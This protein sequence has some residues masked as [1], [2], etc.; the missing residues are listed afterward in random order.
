MSVSA[1]HLW[2]VVDG[3][4]LPHRREWDASSEPRRMCE[5]FEHNLRMLG[6][7]TDES[8]MRL[9]AEYRRF[10]Y[11]KALDGGG[12]TP[13]HDIDEAWHLHMDLGSDL[14]NAFAQATGRRIRHAAGL[15]KAERHAA[16]ARCW[17]LYQREFDCLP[18]QDIW[19]DPAEVR[20]RE[21]ARPWFWGAVCIF[22]V[23]YVTYGMGVNSLT[24]GTPPRWGGFFA[25]LADLVRTRP[26]LVM[27]GMTCLG[28]TAII[29]A[30]CAVMLG[31]NAF[32][33]SLPRIAH[34]C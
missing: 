9:T 2:A 22:V 20:R 6:G 17:S 16:Y 13:P 33:P 23:S 3:W 1:P 28:W 14:D 19:P 31:R 5:S 8:A 12:L 27:T 15:K 11:L 30:F 24:A 4:L 21:F 18:P 32:R 26:D 10:L 29:S 7:W 34:C 25:T